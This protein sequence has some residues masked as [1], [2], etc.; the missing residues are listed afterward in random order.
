MQNYSIYEFYTDQEGLEESIKKL[1]ADLESFN[2]YLPS[3]MVLL[4]DLPKAK[5]EIK[6][7]LKERMNQYIQRIDHSFSIKNYKFAL[8]N[9]ND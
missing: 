2:L 8:E 9:T 3:N 4:K 6:N 7:E 5:N 1:E